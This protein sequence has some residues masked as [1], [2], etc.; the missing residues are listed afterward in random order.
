VENLTSIP[1]IGTNNCN[2]FYEARYMTPES[3]VSAYDEE[4]LTWSWF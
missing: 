3:I 2:D 4:L 1:R